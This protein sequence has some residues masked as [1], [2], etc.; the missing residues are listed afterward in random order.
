MFLIHLFRSIFAVTA[1]R[2]TRI[3]QQCSPF[4]ISF[5]FLVRRVQVECTST[6]R[7]SNRESMP[8]LSDRP[9]RHHVIMMNTVRPIMNKVAAPLFREEIRSLQ[10]LLNNYPNGRS[11]FRVISFL[12]AYPSS[13]ILLSFPCVSSFVICS[14]ATLIYRFLSLRLFPL[15]H[16]SLPCVQQ[17]PLRGFSVSFCL[18]SRRYCV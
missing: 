4:V 2:N 13:K 15:P 8:R 10:V 9:L 18:P 11:Y 1:I 14:L 3:T 17:R 5:I 6:H 16:V 12:F 7:S